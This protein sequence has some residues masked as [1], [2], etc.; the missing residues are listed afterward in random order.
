M[1]PTYR[2]RLRLEGVTLA[3]CGMLGSLVLLVAA[4]ESRADPMNTVVQLVGVAL[5]LAWLGPRSV[6]RA[7]AAAEPL[8]SP[9]VGSGEP[10]PLWQLPVVVVGLAVLAGELAGWDAGL[11]VTLGCVLVGLTQFVFLE[12]MVA[13]RERSNRCRYFRVK[14]SRILRGTR[15]GYVVDKSALRRVRDHGP[16]APSDAA[17]D[18]DVAEVAP[19]G[20]GGEDAGEAQ[21]GD[22]TSGSDEPGVGSAGA[23]EVAGD[24]EAGA[25]EEPDGLG[26]R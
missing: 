13:V 14:G 15:L 21:E 26:E 11:R 17:D 2:E 1:P 23:T 6:R 10:T 12:P 8:F 18:Q 20:G 4:S 24:R 7:V 22:R 9:N 5:L 19:A 25:G 3:G 16:D